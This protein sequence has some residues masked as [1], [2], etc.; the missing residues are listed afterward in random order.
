M[1]RVAY[2]V[3]GLVVVF[4]LVAAVGYWGIYTRQDCDAPGDTCC[5]PDTEVKTRHCHAGLGCDVTSGICQACGAP[6]QPCCDGD[7]T[8]F[9]LRGYTGILLDSRERIE[10][11]N[12]GAACDARLAGDGTSW[13]GT[14][15]CQACGTKQGGP[16]CAPDVRY[17]LGRCFADAASGANLVC[18]DPWAG[19]RG[20]CVP[21]GRHHGDRACLSGI[22][23][24]DD[25]LVEQDGICVACGQPDL[26]TCD[27]GEPCRGGQSVPNKSW[28]R[29]VAAGGANQP[30]LPN[31]G[32]SYQGMFCNARKICEPCGDGGQSCCPAAQGAPC[33]IGECQADRCFACGYTN[34]P[35]CP[36]A[37]P[38]RD[39]SEAD[40]GTCRACGNPGQRCCYT[41]SIRCYDRR[42]CEDGRCPVA[43]AGGGGGGETWKTCSG[44]PVTWTSAARPVAIEDA[45]G[46]VVVTSHY[47]SSPEEAIQCARAQ[48][49]ESVIPGEVTDFP[50][51]VTCP[52]TGCNQ[53][54]YPGRDHDGAESCAEATSP[55]CSVEDGGCP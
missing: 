16:C 47:A 6:G 19:E 33:R 20:A 51:A 39:G 42:R 45:N 10:S 46:C 48:Y 40:G 25:A 30:C 49:G 29:C 31:G 7:Y 54:T 26:P 2:V 50:F 17:A 21:C 41:L 1:R 35:V 4:G 14:R 53:R 13:L 23:C 22:P 18:D 9:S 12:A 15:R 52:S 11:C 27:R 44:Q 5:G 43:G 36:G 55:G 32:C 34:M 37:D 38:C 24:T 8:G 3:A 28:S